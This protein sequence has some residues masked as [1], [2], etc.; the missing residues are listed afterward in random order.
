MRGHAD[1]ARKALGEMAC[2]HT[3]DAG[4]VGRFPLPGRMLLDELLGVGD[5]RMR[6]GDGMPRKALP[7]GEQAR[8]LDNEGIE[9]GADAGSAVRKL[10]RYLTDELAER[11]SEAGG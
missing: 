9:R 6:V 3:D 5:R 4:E 8:G 7:R 1:V 10:Q 11:G 2:R